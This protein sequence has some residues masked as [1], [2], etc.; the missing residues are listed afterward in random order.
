MSQAVNARDVPFDI[1]EIPPS[2]LN[3]GL[4]GDSDS[5]SEDLQ[6]AEPSPL[7]QVIEKGFQSLPETNKEI[8]RKLGQE[9]KARFGFQRVRVSTLFSGT[10]A[11]VDTLQDLLWRFGVLI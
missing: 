3:E 9:A 1:L 4:A 2:W 7:I 5:T 10:D 6:L 8:F 11:C